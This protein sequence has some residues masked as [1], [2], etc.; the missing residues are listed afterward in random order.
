MTRRAVAPE[1]LPR[2]L[3]SPPSGPWCG[4]RATPPSVPRRLCRRSFV[5]PGRPGNTSVFVP[6]RRELEVAPFRLCRHG[7]SEPSSINQRNDG[8]PNTVRTTKFTWITWLPKSLA[9]Q[10]KRVA[11][12]YFLFISVLVL[13]EWS[14]KNW[15]SKVCAGLCGGRP[16]QICKRRVWSTGRHHDASRTT[17]APLM[18]IRSVECSSPFLRGYPQRGPVTLGHWDQLNHGASCRSLV[19]IRVM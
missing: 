7:V 11:N 12:L 2:I 15:R 6:T 13:F 4:A 16:Q 10:F 5:S 17:L 18:T 9:Q 3:S 1:L 14:P 8:H 19:G